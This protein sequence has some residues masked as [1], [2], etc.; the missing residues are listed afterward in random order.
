MEDARLMRWGL[1]LTLVAVCGCSR[2]TG[3]GG[4]DWPRPTARGSGD[5]VPAD[6]VI[7]GTVT[8]VDSNEGIVVL[9]VGKRQ[10]VKL[11]T[12]FL[13]RRKGRYVGTVIADALFDSVASARY[14][15]DMRTDPRAGDDVTSK[16]LGN[17]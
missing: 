8:A 3:Y 17:E 9:D 4:S 6:A 10:G 15:R 5:G 16:I 14:G 13:V 1:A 2:L 7:R 12:A 11:N